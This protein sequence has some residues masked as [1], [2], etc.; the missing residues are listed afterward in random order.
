MANYKF[1]CPFKSECDDEVVCESCKYFIGF[2]DGAN[3]IAEK[4]Q[5]EL[6]KALE[7]DLL[8]DPEDEE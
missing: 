3:F 4:Y 8:D 2:Q 5:E 1:K 6:I 7:E